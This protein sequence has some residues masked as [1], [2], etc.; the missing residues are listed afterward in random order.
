MCRLDVLKNV[1]EYSPYVHL[2]DNKPGKCEHTDSKIDLAEI[3]YGK[4]KG[5]M[6]GKHCVFLI[7]RNYH[8]GPGTPDFIERMPQVHVNLELMNANGQR[9]PLTTDIA[10]GIPILQAGID[11]DPE[12]KIRH[13]TFFVMAVGFHQFHSEAIGLIVSAE[14]EEGS[15][16]YASIRDFRDLYHDSRLCRAWKSGPPAV[17]DPNGIGCAVST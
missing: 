3:R 12:N 2:P 7:L 16:V 6:G 4:I 9:T 10:L 11:R 13:R 17:V 1:Q 15:S 8:D 14:L 5:I